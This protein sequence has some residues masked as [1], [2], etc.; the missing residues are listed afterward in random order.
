MKK[1]KYTLRRIFNPKTK[2][3]MDDVTYARELVEIIHYI[4]DKVEKEF[5]LYQDLIPKMKEYFC[6]NEP[7]KLTIEER[8]K[9]IVEM[10]KLLKVNSG[11]ANLKF[12][13][14]SYSMAFGKKNGRIIE[15][16]KIINQSVTGLYGR[17]E[18]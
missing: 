7:E 17:I 9:I 2:S 10:L 3:S 5:K 13:D 18:L 15:Q 8:E 6:Y 14:S 1:W 16:F 12:L 11:S 4:V